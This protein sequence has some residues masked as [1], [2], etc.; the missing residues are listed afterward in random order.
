MSSTFWRV[1]SMWPCFLVIRFLQKPAHSAN[2]KLPGRNNTLRRILFG[3]GV[4]ML[5][6]LLVWYLPAAR[7]SHGFGKHS[8][9]RIYP[10]IRFWYHFW[11]GLSILLF[12]DD[13]RQWEPDQQKAR[14]DIGQYLPHLVMNFD[15]VPY[16]FF[17]AL[18]LALSSGKLIFSLVFESLAAFAS[19]RAKCIEASRNVG[20]IIAH[21]I[22]TFIFISQFK[23]IFSRYQM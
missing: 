6:I 7:Q 1:G 16:R 22:E 12:D 20:T 14:H 9:G 15:S 13:E 10:S 19:E 5:V 3:A 4:L 23:C 18:G 2:S 11:V 21:R 8:E 17:R